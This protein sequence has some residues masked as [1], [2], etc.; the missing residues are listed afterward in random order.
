MWHAYLLVKPLV[1]EL[2]ARRM[3]RFVADSLRV[4]LTPAPD[5]GVPGRSARRSWG[6]QVLVVGVEFFHGVLADGCFDR[7]ICPLVMSR[8]CSES[9]M[10]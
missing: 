9:L 7:R 2:F 3:S 4:I 1:G 5:G 10:C 8:P 6:G